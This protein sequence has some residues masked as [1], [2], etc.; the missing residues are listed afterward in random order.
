MEYGDR[1]EV[2]Y[3]VTVTDKQDPH[4]LCQGQVRIVSA[5][6]KIVVVEFPVERLTS[7]LRSTTEKPLKGVFNPRQLRHDKA[8]WPKGT[9]DGTATT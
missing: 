3:I 1:V 7:K 9:F 5:S 2:N 4:Y 6:N 8:G